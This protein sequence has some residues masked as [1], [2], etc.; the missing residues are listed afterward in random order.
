MSGY[1]WRNSP[2][3]KLSFSIIPLTVAG[4]VRGESAR[5]ALVWMN[6]GMGYLFVTQI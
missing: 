1:A 2:L 3:A 4:S 5:M 6:P